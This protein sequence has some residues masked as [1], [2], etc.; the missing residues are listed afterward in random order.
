MIQWISDSF[1]PAE[2][3]HVSVCGV[4]GLPEVIKR[5]LESSCILSWM[6]KGRLQRMPWPLCDA[7]SPTPHTAHENMGAVSGLWLVSWG[8][9][10]GSRT[11]RK[12]RVYKTTNLSDEVWK[13]LNQTVATDWLWSWQHARWR[14]RLLQLSHSL[15]RERHYSSLDK[16][17]R[18]KKQRK[19]TFQCLK[20][21]SCFLSLTLETPS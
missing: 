17:I 10:S 12:Y 5:V 11:S 1:G 6:V 13:R 18:N 16:L 8:I 9:K 20:T 3:S 14:R 21:K 15:M 19:K 7:H 2:L 4:S